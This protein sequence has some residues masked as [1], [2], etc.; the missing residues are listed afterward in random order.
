M[1]A[2]SHKQFINI[3]VDGD[4]SK[5]EKFLAKLTGRDYVKVLD[6][7]GQMGVDALANATPV[8]SG[9]TANSWS[10]EIEESD[11]GISIIWSNSNIQ[12]GYFNVALMLQMGHGT[13][14]GGYVKGVDY[15]N[16]ALEPVFDA[17]ADSV[18]LEVTN[19]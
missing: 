13:R 7:Y 15:I 6:K 8:D 11:E 3:E 19:A 16:P 17:M 2:T 1:I 9:L 12:N 14:N 10:Y 5:T 4:W 18:W